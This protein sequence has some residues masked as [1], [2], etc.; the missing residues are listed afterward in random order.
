MPSK[1]F[2]SALRVEE[3]DTLLGGIDARINEIEE[4]PLNEAA[5]RVLSRTIN[6]K[7]DVP[8]FAKS[9]VDGYALK[10]SN[11]F[12]SSVDDPVSLEVVGTVEMGARPETQV[13]DGRCV[14]IPT[15]AMVPP[16]ADAVVK[17]EF[18]ESFK[19]QDGREMEF[20]CVQKPIHPGGNILPAGADLTKGELILE[21]G[22]WL[23]P[24]RLG[25]LAAAG[26]T[27]I[28]VYRK[29]N[30]CYFSTG[31]ELAP[32]GAELLPGYIHDVNSTT[33]FTLLNHSGCSSTYLGIIDDDEASLTRTINDALS[34]G[35]IAICS[36][37]TSKGNRDLFPT[38][39]ETRD[40]MELLVHGVRMKPGKPIVFGKMDKKHVFVLPGNPTSAIMTF[41]RFVQPALRRWSRLPSRLPHVIPAIL[42]KRIYSEFGR[43]ELKPIMLEDG[44]EGKRLAIPIMKGSET[45]TTLA[46]AD[47]YIE[48]PETTEILEEGT[49]VSVR[50]FQ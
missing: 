38:I 40:D 2:L 8:R 21:S 12:D 45:I 4:S 28:P 10:A 31:S 32:P 18:T 39:L 33:I 19:K 5:F 3:F 6:S 15:G 44:D 34:M 30:A 14:Y 11:T 42:E 22:T 48:I 20:V 46:N 26:E 16:G 49:P 23:T 50:L 43:R 7:I 25:C 35:D 17:V 24:A 47:G 41:I 36:G 9:R 1:R 29:I 27:I 37:G 13:S